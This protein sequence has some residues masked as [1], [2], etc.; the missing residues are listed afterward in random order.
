MLCPSIAN[1]GTRTLS[2]EH[3]TATTASSSSSSG[4]GGILG[5][6]SPTADPSSVGC[7]PREQELPKQ[8]APG[9][10]VSTGPLLLLC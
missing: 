3:T 5:R 1:G 8:A 7:L 6:S 2:A 10:L 9:S 4:K